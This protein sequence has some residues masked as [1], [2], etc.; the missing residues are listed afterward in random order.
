MVKPASAEKKRARKGQG[1]G[2]LQGLYCF[3]R[4]L[5]PEYERKFLI[6]Q[7]SPICQNSL[8]RWCNWLETGRAIVTYEIGGI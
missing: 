8:F 4:F 6:G 5:R 1:K 2:R 3:L 7:I